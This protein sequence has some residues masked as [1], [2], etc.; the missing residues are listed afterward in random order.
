[1]KTRKPVD[2]LPHGPDGTTENSTTSSGDHTEAQT[3]PRIA[4]GSAAN[5]TA[6][7]PTEARNGITHYEEVRL[8]RIRKER[9]NK[10]M[11]TMG[12]ADFLLEVIERLMP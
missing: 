12:D 3:F 4:N 8:A 9:E 5:I 2:S 6:P 1:M 7:P 10:F 11:I